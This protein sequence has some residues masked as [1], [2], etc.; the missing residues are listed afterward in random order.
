[1]SLPKRP[2][3]LAELE[4]SL[5]AKLLQEGQ[6]LE[7][8]RELPSNKEIARQCAALAFQ[9]GVLVLGVGE[10]DAAFVASPIDCA[11]VRERVGQI[12][13]DTPQPPVELDSR[14]L[15]AAEPGKGVVWV[16]IPPSPHM[17]HQVG[18]TYYRRDDAR[19]RPMSEAE[20]TGGGFRDRRGDRRRAVRGATDLEEMVPAEALRMPT[21]KSWA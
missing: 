16:E 10:T 20:V 19:T 17:L 15:H 12:A 11:G 3:T 18:G 14:V 9:G 4:V 2:E 5:A 13:Q 8:K 7:F 1:M 6:H 21:G